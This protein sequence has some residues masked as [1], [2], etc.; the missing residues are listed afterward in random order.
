MSLEV[1]LA[2]VGGAA[3]VAGT[4]K[5]LTLVKEEVSV[6]TVGMRINVLEK[7]RAKAAK[8]AQEVGPPRRLAAACM[9]MVVVFGASVAVL[10]ALTH[11]GG[12]LQA[13]V[14]ASIEKFG[15]SI[16]ITAGGLLGAFLAICLV[17][18]GAIYVLSDR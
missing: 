7:M 3:G 1:V 6:R 8:R 5:A 9:I 4:F 2:L 12:P 14:E 13:K 17:G 15:G 16:W 11:I 10:W 18:F